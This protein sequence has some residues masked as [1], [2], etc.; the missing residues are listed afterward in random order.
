MS[1]VTSFTAYRTLNASIFISGVV[2]NATTLLIDWILLPEML[3]ITSFA[4][5]KIIALKT[6]DYAAWLAYII[7][8]REIA[9]LALT[10]ATYQNS[11]YSTLTL[12]TSRFVCTLLAILNGLSTIMADTLLIYVLS[13]FNTL[14]FSISQF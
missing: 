10:L 8:I 14:A 6:T 9:I 12:N 3:G 7:F 13:I 1:W 4:C 11:V 2:L 5:F